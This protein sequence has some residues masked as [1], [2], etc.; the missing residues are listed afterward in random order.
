[1]IEPE[2]VGRLMWSVRHTRYELPTLL[3]LV[4]E[5]MAPE[6]GPNSN[7]D[8]LFNNLKVFASM[9]CAYISHTPT[10]LPC[11]IEVLGFVTDMGTPV[12]SGCYRIQQWSDAS[13]PSSGFWHGAASRSLPTHPPQHTDRAD[14][15]FSA[16]SVNVMVR[17]VQMCSEG[18]CHGAPGWGPCY[19]Q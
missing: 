8:E 5:S 6:C 13:F 16:H 10:F 19:P 17:G 2:C 11:A 15:M 12:A 18:T 9:G 3:S 14:E 4:A 1:M 7:Q